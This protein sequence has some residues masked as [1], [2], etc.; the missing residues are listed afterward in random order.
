M[1]AGIIGYNI[2][3]LIKMNNHAKFVRS[4]ENPA[5]FA[6]AMD[7][8]QNKLGLKMDGPRLFIIH[9]G[10]TSEYGDE[11]QQPPSQDPGSQDTITTLL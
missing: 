2:G 5:G 9:P 1:L 11:D 6:R 7:N 4:I 3:L 8:V 10:M